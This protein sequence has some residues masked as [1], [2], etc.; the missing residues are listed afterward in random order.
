MDI[1][2]YKVN[3]GRRENNMDTRVYTLTE[4][5]LMGQ[6]NQAKELVLNVM[7]AEGVTTKAK[8]EHINE[9]YAII[10]C[11]PSWLGRTI[12]KIIGAADNTKSIIRVV[13]VL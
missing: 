2:L 5:E 4:G 8:A 1:I 13:K 11:R 7:V 12:Q 6:L 3:I 10:V 9:T